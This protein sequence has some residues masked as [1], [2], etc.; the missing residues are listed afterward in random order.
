MIFVN[1][2]SLNNLKNLEQVVVISL[3]SSLLLSISILKNLFL[4]CI[5]EIK[6]AERKFIF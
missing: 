1:Y 5:F 2:P 4:V 3:I 6:V